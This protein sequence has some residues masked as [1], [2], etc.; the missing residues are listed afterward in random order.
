[1]EL[2]TLVIFFAGLGIGVLGT[3]T[4]LKNKYEEAMNMEI[5]KVNRVLYEERM[6]LYEEAEKVNDERDEKRVSKVKEEA[7]TFRYETAKKNYDAYFKETENAAPE[8]IPHDPYI[9]SANE[10][11]TDRA[12]DKITIT[13]YSNADILCEEDE[14]LENNAE[15][16]L[17]TEW[18]EHFDEGEVGVVYVRNEKLGADY[19]V[20]RDESDADYIR[21]S[22]GFG[23]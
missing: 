13:Y 23:E 16:L 2:K 11:A 7:K 6:R 18:K 5:E 10:F 8:E 20:L 9:I 14:V 15:E 4:Y 21:E 19:E 1:M 12:H 3:R 17:G 22:L